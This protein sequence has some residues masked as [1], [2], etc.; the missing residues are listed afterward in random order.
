MF[1]SS[2]FSCR[3]N[4]AAGGV[5]LS[6]T[7]AQEPDKDLNL[8]QGKNKGPLGQSHFPSN[9]FSIFPQFLFSVHGSRIMLLHLE[10]FLLMML[11]EM[12]VKQI[13]FNKKV[14]NTG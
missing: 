11:K 6:D 1:E 9:Y 3:D 8:R 13:V 14:V 10:E 12:Q 4:V 7:S 5:I 2:N